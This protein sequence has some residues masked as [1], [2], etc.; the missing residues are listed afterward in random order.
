[1][2]LIG[3]SDAAV[4]NGYMDTDWVWT[5]TMTAELII[6]YYIVHLLL[7]SFDR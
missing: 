5:L 4:G 1:M 6:C 7:L 3:H 2:V